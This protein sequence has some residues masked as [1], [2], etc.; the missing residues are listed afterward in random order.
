MAKKYEDTG[1]LT[2]LKAALK[3]KQ[4]GRLYIFHGEED[5]RERDRAPLGKVQDNGI[6]SDTRN[7]YFIQS[8]TDS[9]K[10]K[11]LSLILFKSWL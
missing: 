9:R 1:A 5:R 4:P 2:R 11:T 8:G 3:E 10:D 6:S 7:K